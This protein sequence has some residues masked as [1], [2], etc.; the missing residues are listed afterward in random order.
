MNFGMDKQTYPGDA[1]VTGYGE[2]NG[3]KLFVFGHDFT[4]LGGSVGEVVA[5][6]V[7]KVMD[8]VVDAGVPIID[9]NDSGGARIQEGVDSL[10]RFA[11]IFK[12]NTDASGVIPQISCIIMETY[13]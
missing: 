3:R 2:V 9:L 6:K 5:D 1:V 10:V 8:Q 11:H 7:R 12:R 4:V 13:Q